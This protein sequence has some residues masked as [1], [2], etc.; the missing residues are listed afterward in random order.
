MHDVAEHTSQLLVV[1]AQLGPQ[2]C[3]PPRETTSAKRMLKGSAM[4]AMSAAIEDPSESA[5]VWLAFLAYGG[6]GCTK[7]RHPLGKAQQ[8]CLCIKGAS[9]CPNPCPR[10]PRAARRF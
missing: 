7:L 8:K 9:S 10:H 2:S 1:R 3:V 4:Q 5:T 6:C